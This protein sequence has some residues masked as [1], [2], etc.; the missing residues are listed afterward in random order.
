MHFFQQQPQKSHKQDILPK[1]LKIDRSFFV[2]Y[3]THAINYFPSL[4]IIMSQGHSKQR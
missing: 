4:E 1:N 3:G 2:S